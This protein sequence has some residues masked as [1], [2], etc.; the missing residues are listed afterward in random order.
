[1]TKFSGTRMCLPSYLLCKRPQLSLLS[2]VKSV[3]P[4]TLASF[5]FGFHL[6]IYVSDKMLVF[7]A[8]HCNFKM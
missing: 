6:L 7:G 1:M 4:Q 5:V 3:N 2:D 8:N